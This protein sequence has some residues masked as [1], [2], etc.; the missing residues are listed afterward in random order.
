MGKTMHKFNS[1]A[2]SELQGLYDKYSDLEKA[3]WT[4]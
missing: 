4:I 1:A 2:M 3:S